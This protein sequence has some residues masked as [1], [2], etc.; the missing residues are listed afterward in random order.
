MQ[1]IQFVDFMSILRISIITVCYNAETVLEGTLLSVLNQTYPHI[2]YIVV[3]GKSKDGTVS[4]IERYAHRLSCWISEP[5]QGIYDAMNKGQRLATG[6]FVW[7]INAGDRFFASDTVEKAVAL[8]HDDT[9][10]FYGD[11]MLVDEKRTRLATRSEATTQKLPSVLSWKNYRLGMVVCHQGIA[12]RR[13]IAPDYLMN[14][15][16]ADIDWSIRGLKKAKNIVNT[17]LILAEYLKGG[18]SKQK[19]QQSLYDRSMILRAHFGFW[20]N[21]WGHFLI[22]LRA[23][24]FRVQRIGKEHY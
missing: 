4:M 12:L 14:N 3:D 19:H 18:I 8:L 9:D 16:S 15:L 6:D 2:D 1:R 5:D 17:H 24:V 11:V 10:A 7:F 23:I 20:G 21:L 13:N 22:L